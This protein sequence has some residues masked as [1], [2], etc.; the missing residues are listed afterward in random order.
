MRWV[1]GAVIGGLVCHSNLVT[2][3]EWPACIGVAYE[4]GEVGAGNP[5]TKLVPRL[6]HIACRSQVDLVS[7]YLTGLDWC[8]HCI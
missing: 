4:T 5:D 3:S 2:H 6:D 1:I 8:W 7:I